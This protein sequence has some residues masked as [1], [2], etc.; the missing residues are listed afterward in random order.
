MHCPAEVHPLGQIPWALICAHHRPRPFEAQPC[1]LMDLM[2]AS[3][4]KFAASTASQRWRQYEAIAAMIHFDA[5]TTGEC[6]CPSGMMLIPIPPSRRNIFP[7]RSQ[8]SSRAQHF[9]SETS[10]PAHQGEYWPVRFAALGTTATPMH[11]RR[12]VSR[13]RGRTSHIIQSC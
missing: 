12:C 11:K 10:G 7:F 13:T 9:P 2:G 4:S 6:S 1:L 8:S 5:E 3:R